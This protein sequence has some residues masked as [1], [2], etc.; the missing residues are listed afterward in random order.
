MLR[1]EKG[2]VNGQKAKWREIET[3]VMPA[4]VQNTAGRCMLASLGGE[5]DMAHQE[6]C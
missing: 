2:I 5:T 6:V 3:N 1:E 4:D